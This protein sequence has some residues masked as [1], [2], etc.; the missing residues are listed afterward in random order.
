MRSKLIIIIL[1]LFLAG[2]I[3]S[4]ITKG[5]KEAAPP[6]EF[7]QG[8]VVGG[9]P[10]LPRYP[11]LRIVESVKSGDS[12]GASFVTKDPID[13]VLTFYTDTLPQLGWDSQMIKHSETN[14][15]LKSKN[16]QF[17]G[18]II[19]NVAADGTTVA[20]TYSFSPR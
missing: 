18:I 2:C 7:A 9:F 3:P 19:I 10:N 15:E 8:A 4:A 14:Y 20:V 16:A 11:K 13:K 17:E 5:G 6:G 12:F 1:P